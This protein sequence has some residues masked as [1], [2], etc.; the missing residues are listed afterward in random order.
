MPMSPR[1]LRPRST[2][3]HPEAQAWRNAVIANG[4][5]VSGSTLTA[6]SNFCRSIDAAGI[7]DRFYRLNLFA[8]T[9]LSACLVPLYRG[10]SWTGT[11]YGGTTDTNNGPFVSG[12]YV[13]TG[14]SGGLTG[15]GSKYLDTGLAVDAMPTFA[16]GHAAC[17]KAAGSAANRQMIGARNSAGTQFIR[18]FK[19]GSSDN[20]GVWG[21]AVI[22]VSATNKDDAGFLVVS[23]TSA[24]LLRLYMNG[25]QV[26]EQTT[27]ATTTAFNRNI[28]VFADNQGT[29]QLIWNVTTAPLRAYS[30][31][32]SMTGSQVTAFTNAM[33]TF[34]TALSRA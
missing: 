15:N 3:F 21:S 8:G 12:D 17:Y 22:A 33:N 20:D 25:S 32:D 34:Q 16:T 10:Q 13:E 6:V 11:Q 4:G 2:G 19:Q 1:L 18:L 29:A 24:T 27:S 23:R 9:G 28:F 7:R 30:I 31:G 5:T 26:N 14:T